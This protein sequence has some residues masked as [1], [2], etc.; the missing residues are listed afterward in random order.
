MDREILELIRAVNATPDDREQWARLRRAWKRHF[1]DKLP[2]T[3]DQ[4][5]LAIVNALFQTASRVLVLIRYAGGAGSRQ[6]LMLPSFDSFLAQLKKCKAQDDVTVMFSYQIVREGVV[7]QRFSEHVMAQYNVD[8][9]W[10]I[11]EEMDQ[12]G[13]PY[14]QI[15][16]REELAAELLDL[17]G[18][19]VC[20]VVDPDWMDDEKAIHAYLP[21]PDGI[22]R[23]GAY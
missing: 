23:P 12:C 4:H 17:Y 11:I 3:E 1:P 16:C 19:K 8:D 7:D 22:V 20:I 2:N 9:E 13:G 14:S 18:E 10:L 6:F 21:D 15:D 5:Y